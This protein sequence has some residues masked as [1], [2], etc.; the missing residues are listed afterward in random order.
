M[1]KIAIILGRGVEGCG[2]TRCA[3]EFQKATP[4]TKI[5]ATLDKKWARRDTMVFDKDEFTCANS[6]EM[7]RVLNEVNENFDMALIYSVPSKKHPEDCQTNFVK[8]VQ[9]IS[10]PKAI[11]QLD[12][13]MQ[14]LSRNGKFDEI[15][16]SVDVLMTHSLESDFT[17]WATRENVTT[18]FKKMALGFTYDD[19][20]KKYWLPIEEQ[21][22]KTVRWIGRLS[23]WKGPNLMMDFHASQLMN[24]DYITVLE[25]LEASI[26][27]AGILYEKGDS[28]NGTPL[29]KDNEIVN[30]FR[31]RKELDE[32]KF[33]Q[34]LYGKEVPGA[35]AYLY[36]PYTN[37]DCM[38]R[39]AKSAYGSDLYHLK[40]HMY[41]N[42]IENC[43]A[44]V[45]ASGTIPI[46]HKHFCDN[47][48]HRTTG[49]PISQD[50]HSGTI[51][52][53]NTNFVECSDLMEKLSND[54]V[55]RD[56][57]R[58]M[59]FAYWKDHS[60]ASV[61]TLEIIKNL[62]DIVNENGAKGASSAS[63]D[64]QLNLFS[65]EE[66]VN[67]STQEEMQNAAERVLNNSTYG[68]FGKTDK[69]ST[70][71]DSLLNDLKNL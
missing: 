17:R 42:N 57:M 60:D 31:P 46:F 36:P 44:E 6:E 45:I 32:V 11:V 5:F 38:K 29:Y 3:V 59:S 25:G 12:H 21:D 39:M 47:V 27:W 35:G 30:Y 55:M 22:H 71:Y 28:K 26:G 61:T 33:T 58:E 43:H 68:A 7:N 20:R 2:V 16:S 13:K 24:K 54:P 66:T 40:A 18:P 48:I 19:H 15:C 14:S 8:L 37:V 63:G 49:N 69:D 62:E 64:N 65:N 9:G 41:G 56:E 34:D 23:G 10:L 4:N 50:K 70:D 53:D 1:K 67:E 52:L 51:G